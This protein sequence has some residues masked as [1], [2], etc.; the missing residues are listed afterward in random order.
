M[1]T[2]AQQ[3]NTIFKITIINYGITYHSVYFTNQQLLFKSCQDLPIIKTATFTF[4]FF[5]DKIREN[6]VF[7]RVCLLMLLSVPSIN[8]ESVGLENIFSPICSSS[9]YTG[10]FK[11]FG[12]MVKF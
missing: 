5:I 3:I 12:H 7:G 1:E 9:V 11:Y 8:F 6:N 2:K 10:Q 4:I